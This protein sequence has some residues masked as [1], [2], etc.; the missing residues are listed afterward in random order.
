MAVDDLSAPLGQDK[1]PGQPRGLPVGISRAVAGL[2]GLLLA[3]FVGWAV[4]VDDPYGGEPLAIVPADL[5]AAQVG[6]PEDGVTVP[7]AAP[8]A[9]ERPNRHDG[10]A[11]DPAQPVVPATPP[12]T[13]TI[14][15]GS[16]GTRQEI[17]I[18]NGSDDKSAPDERLT[19]PS[20]H[21]PLPKIAPDGARPSE[22]YARP[23][24]AIPNKPNAPRVAI[25]VAGLGIG[26]GATSDAITKLP[27]PVTLAIAPYG[28]NLAQL[29]ARARGHGH[30]ILLQVP[31]EPFD[32]PDNDPGPQTLL[33]TLEAAQ[34]LDRLHWSMS[35]FHGYVGITNYMGAR[36]STTEQALTPVLR[37][38][39]NRGLIYVDDGLSPH[40]LAGRIAAAGSLPYAKSDVTIDA[41]PNP[42][43]I[44]RALGR[45]ENI[46]RER[47]MA[48]GYAN[49][50]PVAIE[51]IAR[52]AKAAEGRGIL[53]VPI[54]AAASKAKSS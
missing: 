15:D 11:T 47:G 39:G 48:I 4:V 31:M 17:V 32:Y 26:A 46:A 36:F 33:T 45:L 34:N 40:G 28:G 44:D 8:G 51:R 2:L 14:I 53:L 27:G 1:T 37:D 21:G 50:L 25:V 3:I 38:L 35:R 16:S 22:V 23:V 49:A 7:P 19:E 30:E 24:R 29:A 12:K 41:V 13:V 43:D 42:V 52:W 9:P 10:P 20:R 6:A 5:R 18:G 54:S